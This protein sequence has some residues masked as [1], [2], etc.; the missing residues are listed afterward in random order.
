[1]VEL[2]KAA[3]AMLDELEASEDGLVK[4]AIVPFDV[5]VRVPTSYKTAS[6][7]KTDWWVSL[8][9]ERMS[10]PIATSPTT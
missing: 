7:F 9:L 3:K 10:L 1:M 2:K 5:N 6:W 4:I 8:V